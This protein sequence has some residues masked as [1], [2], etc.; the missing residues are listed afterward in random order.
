M[1]APMSDATS[2]SR[3]LFERACAVLPGGVNSPVRAFRAVGGSPVFIASAEGARLRSED[4]VEYIDYVGSWGP[5]ILGHAHPDVVQ[6]VR[7]AAGSGLSFG[8]PTALEVRFAERLREIYPTL[9]RLRCVSSGT[10]ATMSAIRVARGFTR[11][12]LV[13]KF[14]GCYHGHADHLLVKAGSG[15]ATFGVPDSG[16]VPEGIARTTLTLPFNDAAALEGAFAARGGEIAAV[17][18]EPVVGNM[19]CV[20]PEP[21]FLDCVVA[22]CREH[23]AL[24]IFDEV[25]TGCRVA[26]GGAQERYGVRP[27][28]TTLGKVIGGGM[29]LAAYGGREDVMRVVAPLGP[30]YQAG[31][32]SGNPVAVSAGLAT[33]DRLT[34]ALYERLE[35]LGAALEEGL[36]G[37]AR[38]AGVPACVQRVGSM[39][40]LFFREGPVRSW[41]DAAGSDTKRFAAWHGAMLARG[42]YWPP[43]QYE[44]A[45]LS[46]AHTDDDIRRTVAACR[47]ALAG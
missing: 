13:I 9:E 40:T 6:A 33:L 41:G 19:G 35:A 24:S 15:L 42:V 7:E 25:M 5:A 18:L 27:D 10:E 44:A 11:R 45:F 28:M 21:G 17:I 34:P 26:R 20:P 14:E 36:R 30:V 38:D 8:A 16:G 29:P 46:G 37:A 31:T 23:G 3:A 4:G 47:E 1:A 12:D 22:L 39:I 32:L 2:R 43:S